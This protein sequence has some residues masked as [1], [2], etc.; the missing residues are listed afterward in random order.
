MLRKLRIKDWFHSLLGD[1]RF[2]LRQIRKSPVFAA[3]AVL[4]LALG[5]GS[6]T[7]IFSVIDGILLHPYP[8]KNAERLATIR[9]FSADQFRAWRF[10][11][12]AFVDFKEHN[13]SFED[14]FGLV[15][16]EL[17]FTKADTTEKLLGGSVSS[18]TFESLGIPALFGR[19]L[20]AED[21]KPG[22]AP[23]FVVSYSLWTKLFNRDPKVL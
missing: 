19:A 7:A 8:Y 13:H 9:V 18:G 11:A 10:P 5:I 22:A 6:S 12:R 15:Y 3:V 2:A 20:T 17:R 21:Y 4:T 1:C 23:V 14:M 16:R